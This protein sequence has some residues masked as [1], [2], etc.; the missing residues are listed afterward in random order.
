MA[1]IIVAAGGN[2]QAAINS[3]TGG[4]NI[5][6]EAGATF[7]GNFTLPP[8]SGTGYVTIKSNT[9]LPDVSIR[10]MPSS[11][12]SFAKIKAVAGGL[13]AIQF[14]PFSQYWNLTGLE[15]LFN[16]GGFNEVISIGNGDK[17]V[18][19]TL[20]QCPRYVVIDRC[21]IH[22]SSGLEF[23]KR[24]IGANG[25][26]TTIKNCCITGVRI[27]GQDSQ[28]IAG[29]NGPGPCTIYNNYL[30]ASSEN[31]LFGG[32]DSASADLMPQNINILYNLVCKRI[33]WMSDSG[34]NE[35]N[36][37]ELKVGINVNINYNTF[38]GCWADAQTGI[39]ILFTVRNQDETAPWSEIRNVSFTNNVIRNASGGINVSAQD[40]RA[41]STVVPTAGLSFIT[42]RDNLFYNISNSFGGS[43]N[44]YQFQ[45]GGSNYI[46]DHNTFI[47]T[48][49]GGSVAIYLIDGISTNWVWTN[50]IYVDNGL[51]VFDTDGHFGT[52]ALN[53]STINYTFEKNVM[54]SCPFAGS[55]PVNN[56]SPAAIADVEFTNVS[57][58]NYRLLE[59]S[60][61]HNQSTTGDDIGV[62]FDAVVTPPEEPPDP[63]VPPSP[64]PSD[65]TVLTGPSGLYVM[66]VNRT[67]D[68]VYLDI[69]TQTMAL[70]KIIDPSASL[71]L[72]GDE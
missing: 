36:L 45:N 56:Y 23:Q 66:V 67:N 50:N 30:E 54:I 62:R 44:I 17:A 3:A 27:S 59:T 25:R 42:V 61:Y 43:G 5:L 6:L 20:A 48:Q 72:V 14:D 4:D 21:Y 18:Q 38:D 31:I 32:A 39:P 69:T 55:Y 70:K 15:F 10:V 33:A 65:E 57:E 9:V 68:R 41:D 16:P 34:Y 53:A 51:G 63:D 29:F 64:T 49:G 47:N 1:D 58:N 2:L 24:A 40:V 19:T 28:A 22:E 11:A 37:L 7:T 13:P 8:H 35:K 71:Y 26:D 60:P 12:V 52:A 46:T